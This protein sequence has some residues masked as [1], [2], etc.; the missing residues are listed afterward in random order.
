M[1]FPLI[2][3]FLLLSGTIT[4]FSSQTAKKGTNVP[5]FSWVVSG[6]IDVKLV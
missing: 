5:K 1:L 3:S 6:R 4:I 2:Y